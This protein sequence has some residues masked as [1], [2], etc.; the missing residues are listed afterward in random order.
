MSKPVL[1]HYIPK[2]YLR[3]FQIDNDKNKS[4]VYCIDFSNHFRKGAQR[5]GINDKVF[6][7]PKYYNDNRLED[8]FALEKDIR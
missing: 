6:K 1:Q 7:S 3:Q 8:P 2:T 4:F 5:L